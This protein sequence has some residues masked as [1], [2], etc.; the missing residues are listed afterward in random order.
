MIEYRYK[1]E[2]YLNMYKIV[3]LRLIGLSVTYGEQNGYHFSLSLA[4]GPFE[5]TIGFSIWKYTLL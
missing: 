3:L 1:K 5:P 4:I 2:S